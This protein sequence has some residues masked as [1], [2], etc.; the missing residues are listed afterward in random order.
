M[1]LVTISDQL[2]LANDEPATGFLRI[3]W[4]RFLKDGKNYVQCSL[5]ALI[6]LEGNFTVELE[7]SIDALPPFEYTVEYHTCCRANVIQE[8]WRVPESAETLT[9][10]DVAVIVPAPEPVPPF[11]TQAGDLFTYNGAVNAI[12]HPGD[13]GQVLTVDPDAQNGLS[14]SYVTADVINLP[15]TS[16]ADGSVDNTEFQYLDGVT[17]PIQT[18][19]DA[20]T[21]SIATTN[22]N[23]ATTNTN[24]A[25]L[26]TRLDVLEPAVSAIHVVTTDTPLKFTSVGFNT[27]PDGSFVGD[28]GPN[29]IC[30]GYGAKLHVQGDAVTPPTNCVQIGEGSTSTNTFK[31]G[32][33]VLFNTMSTIPFLHIGSYTPSSRTDQSMGY[34]TL[35]LSLDSSFLWVSNPTELR[36]IPLGQY[37]PFASDILIGSLAG[38]SIT[39]GIQNTMIGQYVC[40]NLTTAS[41]VTAIGFAAGSYQVNGPNTFVGAF[42]GQGTSGNTNNGANNIAIGTNSLIA[43]NTGGQNVAVGG[44]TLQSN[45]TASNCVAI[46]YTAGQRGLS[47]PNVYIGSQSGVGPATGTYTAV[48]NTTVGFQA[49]QNIDT[50][51]RNTCVGHTAGMKIQTNNE[52]TLIGYQAGVNIVAGPDWITAVGRSALGSLTT[53][54]QCTAVGGSALSSATGSGNTG[55]GY[56]VGLNQGTGDNNTYLGANAGQGCTTGANNLCVG[57]NAKLGSAT[58]GAIQVGAGTNSADNTMQVWGRKVYDSVGYLYPIVRTPTSSA[59]ASVPIGAI[60]AD[61]NF[62]YVCTAAG[63]IKR[64]ALTTF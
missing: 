11:F 64:V 29:C 49:L 17:S 25:A 20:A 27:G 6:D 37:S 40:R 10:E 41:N 28:Q 57:Q 52:C 36:Q 53:G 58:S 48:N 13:D 9:L 38:G 62:I 21:S 7:P 12:L 42:A 59:D 34:T 61:A 47:G 5:K 22:T 14:W 33:T 46:G 15:A 2:W 55:L 50:G 54:T 4:P 35:F 63:V 31:W 56:A 26:D 44:A 24:V 45:L 39:T 43:L 8:M 3:S 18:Q 60:W 23:L 1:A 51:S 32:S 19:V 30:L 16:I